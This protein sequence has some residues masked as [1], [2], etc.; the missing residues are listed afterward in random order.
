[1]EYSGQDDY[2][3]SG[4]GS[5][6]VG[7]GKTDQTGFAITEPGAKTYGEGGF[8]L[9]ATGGQSGGNVTFTVSS[10]NVIRITPSGAV[11]IHNAGTVT[12]TATKAGDENYNAVISTLKLTV[13]KRNIENINVTVSGDTIYKGS[14]LQ[15]TFT[16][17]DS[18]LAID[19][20][21]YSHDYG[22]NITVSDGGSIILTGQRNYT[23]TKTVNFT[24]EKADPVYTLPAGLTAT[25]GDTLSSV[26]LPTGW[27][28]ETTGA[29]GSAGNQ[30]HKAAFTPS[31]TANYNILT[32]IAV[33][34]TVDKMA[35]TVTAEDKEKFFGAADPALTYTISVELIADDVLTGSLKYAG[36]NVGSYDVVEDTPFDNPTYDIT[37]V[38]GTMTIKQ[39]P[40]T[41]EV[42]DEVTD[43]PDD[44][45]PENIDTVIDAT[46]AFDALPDGEKE[47]VP[48]EIKDKLKAAQEQVRIV[49]S[50]DQDIAFSASDLPWYIRTGS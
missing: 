8:T 30:A 42:I 26:D 3:A 47:Q 29:V 34:V 33:T 6:T 37:F 5:L 36:S 10:E 12:V 23:G 25:Y 38:S 41:D 46:K 14:Q 27:A 43:L 4:I 17:S 9:S 21:D 16:V 15:P 40:A 2:Y 18:S 19:T 39:T 22:E 11:T 1:M 48:Q 7:V 13:S 35:V 31:D 32:D 20:G 50:K 49:N 44:I 24:I 28:W 45:T